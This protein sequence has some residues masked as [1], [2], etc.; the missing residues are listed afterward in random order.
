MCNISKTLLE[1]KKSLELAE[2]AT[3]SGGKYGFFPTI[4]I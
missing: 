2:A 4:K 3:V 1:K